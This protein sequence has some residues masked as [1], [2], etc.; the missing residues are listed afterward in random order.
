MGEAKLSLDKSLQEVARVRAELEAVRKEADVER[1][2]LEE[3]ARFEA[4]RPR[5]CLV[6]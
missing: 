2:T 4:H 5:R 1:T 3:K 6:G